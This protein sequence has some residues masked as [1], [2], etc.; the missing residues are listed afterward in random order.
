MN[1]RRRSYLEEGAM[2]TDYLQVGKQ[3]VRGHWRTLK[4]GKKV[5][6]RLDG[7]TPYGLP[8]I[9]GGLPPQSDQFKRLSKKKSLFARI[10]TALKNKLSKRQEPKQG[11]W[12]KP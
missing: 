10:A 9:K 3:K 2:G 12:Y 6:F 1:L 4:N 5:F 11:E 7:G 8:G